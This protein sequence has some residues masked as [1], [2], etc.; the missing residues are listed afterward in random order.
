LAETKLANEQT[1]LANEKTEHGK[2][3]TTLTN[4][5]AQRNKLALANAIRAGK[6]TPAEE[7]D[8]NTKL[9]ENWETNSAALE[10]KRKRSKPN[11]AQRARESR[12]V[13]LTLSNE[14]DIKL[15]RGKVTRLVNEKAGGA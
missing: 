8:W 12:R 3:K 1:A 6:I 5:I 10:A 7:A 13:T 11:R 15:R 14:E 9:I 2:T 4:V